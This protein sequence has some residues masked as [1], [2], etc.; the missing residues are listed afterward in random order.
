[1]SFSLKSLNSSEIDF[2]KSVLYDKGGSV[3][4]FQE[5]KSFSLKEWSLRFPEIRMEFTCFIDNII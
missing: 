4:I 5:K 3:G 2:S 1:L